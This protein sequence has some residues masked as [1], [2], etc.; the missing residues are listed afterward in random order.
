M[1]RMNSSSVLMVSLLLSVVPT[2]GRV[3]A[4]PRSQKRASSQNNGTSTTGCSPDAFDSRPVATVAA[5]VAAASAEEDVA[6][7][8]EEGGNEGVALTT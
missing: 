1:R 4:S 5:V 6:E 7:E 8:E 2:G 3:L